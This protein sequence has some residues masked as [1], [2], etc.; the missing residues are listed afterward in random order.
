MS[1]TGFGTAFFVLYKDDW[2]RYKNGAV[3]VWPEEW[4]K[5][6]SDEWRMG[7]YAYA[8][9][10]PAALIPSS[11]IL[12]NYLQVYTMMLGDFS[13]LETLLLGRHWSEN[14]LNLFWFSIK[15]SRYLAS[16]FFVVFTFCMLV[17]LLNVIIAIMVDS[18]THLRDTQHQVFY[19]A[20][21]LNMKI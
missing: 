18:Y 12:R 2:Q 13:L 9:E 20:L 21:T 10:T 14:G 19:R 16:I 6:G 5:A 7:L 15:I 1:P 17:V 8:G 11:N 3:T 4:S